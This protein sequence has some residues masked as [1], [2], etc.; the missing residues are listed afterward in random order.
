MKIHSWPTFTKIKEV[1]AWQLVR[2]AYKIKH[3]PIQK[4][5]NN[6]I[7]SKID[8]INACWIPGHTVPAIEAHKYLLRCRQVIINDLKAQCQN[9]AKYRW[10]WYL[11]RMPNHLFDYV[12]T[13]QSTTTERRKLAEFIVDV[14]A[15]D[16]S[17]G[18]FDKETKAI[19]FDIDRRIVEQLLEFVFTTNELNRIDSLIRWAAKGCDFCMA[20]NVKMLLPKP[21]EELETAVRLYDT[22]MEGEAFNFYSTGTYKEVAL[23]QRNFQFPLVNA[24]NTCN[25]FPDPNNPQDNYHVAS[26]DF[27]ELIDFLTHPRL[28]SQKYFTDTALAI[29]LALN[30]IH[31]EVTGGTVSPSLWVCGYVLISQERIDE[32]LGRS[33]DAIKKATNGILDIGSPNAQWVIQK[34][35][36]ASP[37]NTVVSA[38]GGP[39]VAVAPNGYLFNVVAANQRLYY[40][41][42]Y[43][44][45]GGDVANFRGDDFE[46][47]VQEIINKTKWKPS[48]DLLNY[49]GRHLKNDDGNKITDLD[50]LA[51]LDGNLIVF[52]C[53]SRPYTM[54]Y[55]A[56]EYSVVRSGASL[57]TEAVDAAIKVED[58]LNHN[59]SG[60][61]YDFRQY[62]S[63]TICVCTPRVLFVPCG[64]AT[65]IAFPG[66]ARYVS[67][68]EVQR[69]LEYGDYSLPIYGAEVYTS[70]PYKGPI[71]PPPTGPQ[72]GHSEIWKL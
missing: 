15:A 60:P 27:V 44:S 9:F 55:D 68:S 70:T 24:F 42:Q 69:F 43:P 37:S 72:G 36:S 39:L 18:N 34:L 11:R 65:K 17:E 52:S 41:L 12:R 3:I 50:A 56:G 53:K 58:I 66:L 23:S 22:R 51:E 20:S 33:V 48:H 57:V 4:K 35:N 13:L 31:Y 67:V 19:V 6:R 64:P 2:W 71:P 5:L 14:F 38:F 8:K 61:N 25:A 59:P 49:R 21:T 62:K 54:K 16:K 32:K 45:V 46:L 26:Y 47:A 30:I 7:Y 28:A 40:E 1:E 10:V 29:V 63:I